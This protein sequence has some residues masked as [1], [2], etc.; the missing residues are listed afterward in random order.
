MI[1]LTNTDL[2]AVIKQKHLDIVTD[3]DPS[4]LDTAES[5]AMGEMEG[6]L[7][8]RYDANACLDPSSKIPVISMY[9]ADITLYHAHASVMP[10]NIPKLRLKRYDDAKEWLE[11][12]ASGYINPKLPI[13]EEA[14]TNPLRYGNSADKQ[15]QYF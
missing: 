1:Y 12:I 7:S 4:V 10:D 11:K 9:L 13:K 15:S 8:V 3:E 6:Y 5:M 2:L 14:P